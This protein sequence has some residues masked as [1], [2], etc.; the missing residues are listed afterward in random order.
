MAGSEAGGSQTI[1]DEAP[2]G[3]DGLADDEPPHVA[4]ARRVAQVARSPMEA[5]RRV[6]RAALSRVRAELDI[7]PSAAA[8][9]DEAGPRTRSRA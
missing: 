5:A 2:L 3:D 6:A 7:S 1:D 8:D 4:A 9:A